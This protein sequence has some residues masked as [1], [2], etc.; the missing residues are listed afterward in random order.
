MKKDV[1]K[2]NNKNIQ[3]FYKKLTIENVW[4]SI[5]SNGDEYMHQIEKEVKAL[6]LVSFI[7]YMCLCL[8]LSTI[9]WSKIK[10]KFLINT[11][12]NKWNPF[13]IS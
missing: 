13:Q 1:L 3:N 12:I 7:Q 5:R 10:V 4:L 11:N 9:L 8:I 6:T 2:N